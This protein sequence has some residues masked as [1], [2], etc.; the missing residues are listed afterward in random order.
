M[1]SLAPCFTVGSIVRCKTCFGDNISGEVKLNII[2]YFY[3]YV[4][5][6]I[7][8]VVAFDLGVKMLIMKCPSSNGGGDEQTTCNVTIV[9]LSLC[10][11]IE[12]VK[13]AIPPAEVQQPEPI[14]LPMVEALSI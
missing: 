11:D 7:S 9:N 1:S 12:I 5:L 3:D 6:S 10:M 4:M 14:D 13:E 8:Q 2:Y